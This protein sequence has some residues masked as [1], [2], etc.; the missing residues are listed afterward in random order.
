MK[1]NEEN[2]GDY[3]GINYYMRRVI[4]ADNLN[5]EKFED[6]FKFIKVPGAQYTKWDWEVYPKG[7]I[8]LLPHK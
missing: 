4:E 8:D 1:I 7:L 3:L 5:S 6:K 2:I